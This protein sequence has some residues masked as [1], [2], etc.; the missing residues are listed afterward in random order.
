M[1]IECQN[2]QLTSNQKGQPLSWFQERLWVHNQKNPDD[3]SYNIPVVFQLEGPLDLSALNRSLNTII[4]RHDS[5]RARFMTAK[6]GEPVQVISPH[7]ELQIAVV[8]A[9]E[10]QI[11]DYIKANLEYVFDLS[12]GPMLIAKI[13][14][15]GPEKHIL[16]INV[17]HISADGWSIE[18]VFFAELRGCYEAF[19][20]GGLP[21]LRPLPVQYVDFA[22]WQRQQDLLEQLAYWQKHLSDYEDTLLLPTDFPRRAVSGRTSDSFTYEY[23]C[24]FSQKLERFSQANGCTLFMSLI[25]GF[26]LLVNRYTGKED[27]CI[28]TT[29]SGR[30]QPELEGLIGFFINILPL[31]FA[32]DETKSVRDYVHH[33]RQVSI[34]GFDHQM[35]PFERILFSLGLDRSK[36]N[37]PLVPLILR[38]QNFPRSSLESNSPGGLKFTQYHGDESVSGMSRCELELSYTGDAHA[39]KIEVCYAADLYRRETI[40]RI[41]RQHERLLEAMFINEDRPLS[42]LSLLGSDDIERFCVQYNQT[43]KPLLETTFVQRFDQ[44]V[45]R[46]PESIACVD[47]EGEWSYAELLSI[48]NKIAH[49]L[50]AEGIKPGDIVGVCIERRKLL[51]ACLLGVW[52]AGAAYVPLDPSYPDTYLHQITENAG[53]V[54]IL[55]SSEVQV[56]AGFAKEQCIVLD[57]KLECLSSISEESPKVIITAND[58]AYLM[59]TS[60]STGTPKGVRVP[61]RQLINWLAGIESRWPFEPDEIV[62][63]KT[64]FAFAVGVKE[65]FAGLLNGCKIAMIKPETTQDVRAFVAALEIYKV[66]RLNL[67]PSHL[68]TVLDYLRENGRSLPDLKLCTTAGEA[69]T[70]EVVTAFRELLPKARLLNNFGCTELNDITY[71]DTADY[72]GKGFVPI[73]KPIQNTKLYVL[74]R[75]GRLVPEGVPGELY[76]STAGMSNGYHKLAEMT[77]ERYLPNRFEPDSKS[78][79][80]NTGDVVRYL[81]DGNIE[82]LGRWDFQVKIRG[83]RVDV[84]HVEKTIKDF[85]GI[86]TV[87]VVGDGKQLI[88]YYVLKDNQTLNIGILREFLQARLPSYM[89]PTTFVMMKAM[90]QL[91]NGK[92]NRL[93]LKPSL[94]VLQ[95]SV[96]YAAP[97][98]DTERT[99]AAIWSEV[100]QVAEDE[101]GRHSNFFETGG[102]SLAAVRVVARIKERLHFELGLSILFKYP[103]LS[104]L[105]D[106]IRRE[107]KDG[108]DES[109]ETDNVII[110]RAPSGAE[111]QRVPGLLENKVVLVTGSSRGIGSAAVRLLASQGA[112]V[113][114]NY[115]QSD[116]RAKRVKETIEQ[117]GGTAEIFKADVTSMEQINELVEQVHTRF[118][119]IDA[120]VVNAAIG[121]RMQSFIDYEWDDF[122]RKVNDELKAMFYL[123]KAVVPEMIERRNGSI[124]AVSSTMSKA[125]ENCFIAHSTAK[126]ALDAFVRSLANEIGQY[127]VRVNTVAPGL[128]LTDA[129]A[130]LSPQRKDAASSR[131]PLRRNGLPNDV[132][133]AI[134]FLA[135]D[136]SQFMTGTYIPVDGGFTML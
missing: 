5:L 75:Q 51:I 4:N 105:S 63:Q 113:A 132:A 2:A 85:E 115:M 23:S 42:E 90:P 121:F 130:N 88:A 31:R 87:A 52:K 50:I 57:S 16:L 7:E 129:T 59:Y 8:D 27:L 29:T 60:G 6:T 40:E 61:H 45:I 44:Q 124:I 67:V 34:E 134:L 47:S 12:K 41:L 102:H 18:N 73:G 109:D 24:D 64:T 114:I 28:G 11:P 17:H 98:N 35:V 108:V 32:I 103:Q 122:S 127:N 48:S 37:N 20:A 56:K 101:I 111:N 36:G 53:P 91:P 126:A 86:K 96:P 81:S 136:L 93:A 15:I 80:Y 13:V 120:L 133:G 79:L 71:Y 82:Y 74:D 26:S 76:V 135:S 116:V 39:L 78:C 125:A 97:N 72:N 3:T 38:H 33:V 77:E 21:K 83:F 14:R 25:A 65:L 1:T 100:L 117:D 106:Y 62:G 107:Q 10:E 94:G 104:E 49:V 92:M 84:R 22:H 131:C 112:K 46:T 128:T 69:L 43:D 19:C 30:T 68:A 55:C 89:V 99:L 118:G 110:K 95:G 119:E 70:T 54:R 66:T 9:K 58:L 123:C